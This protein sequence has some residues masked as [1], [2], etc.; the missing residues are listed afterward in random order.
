[1]VRNGGKERSLSKNSVCQDTKKKKAPW[2][3]V[4][5]VQLRR[6]E[7]GNLIVTHQNRSASKNEAPWY[8]IRIEFPYI[9]TACDP[10]KHPH[11]RIAGM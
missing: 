1:M 2:I 8:S 4:L 3:S 5:L 11:A 9:A 7:R 10:T 6:I